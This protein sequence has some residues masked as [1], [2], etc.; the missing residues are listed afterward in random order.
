MLGVVVARMERKRNAGT[1]LPHCAT[2]HAG[3][4]YKTGATPDHA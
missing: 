4:K 1:P 2:L 3:Y